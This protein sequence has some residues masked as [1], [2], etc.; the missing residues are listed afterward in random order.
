MSQLH[1]STYRIGS[2]RKKS[3]GLRI[4]TVRLLPRGVPKREYSRRDLFDIW[5]PLV[6]PSRELLKAFQS[7]KK[8]AAEFFRAYRTEMK[9]PTARHTIELLAAISRH[10]PIAVGCYCENESRCHRSVLI[11]LIRAASKTK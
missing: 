2:P 11:K 1:V 5:L 10:T 9:Q 7:G 6:A 3:E 4:G 8:T